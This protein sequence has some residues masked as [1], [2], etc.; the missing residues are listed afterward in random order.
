MNAADWAERGGVREAGVTLD[1]T[2]GGMGGWVEGGG[3][4]EGGG[5]GRDSKGCAQQQKE[6]AQ[7]LNSFQE[8]EGPHETICC[9]TNQLKQ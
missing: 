9:A 7:R 4:K 6:T 5:R 3:R 8:E 2:E 1:E